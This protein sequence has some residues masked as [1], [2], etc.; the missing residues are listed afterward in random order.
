MNIG[1]Q[2][3]ESIS[4]QS[5]EEIFNAN[6][7]LIVPYNHPI[8]IRIK[9]IVKKLA[10][11]ISDLIPGHTTNFQV[12]VVD[13][14]EPNAF[15]LPGGQIFVNTGLLPIALNDDGLATVLAHEVL[16]HHIISAA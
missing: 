10:K 9:L 11:N 5:F 4:N 8:S 12:F 7:H 14:P 2:Q 15:V 6:R 16:N 3:E 13:S 1:I